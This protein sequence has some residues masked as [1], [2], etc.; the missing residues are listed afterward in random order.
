[1][2]I[3]HPSGA[4]GR[5]ERTFI[6]PNIFRAYD[7]RGRYPDDINEEAVYK[8]GQAFVNYTRAKQILVARDIRFSSEN[9]CNSLIKGICSQGASVLDIGLCSTSCFYFAAATTGVDA[10]LM[11][12]ASHFGKNFNGLKPV[13]AKNV[14]LT[15]DEVKE[16]KDAVIRKEYNTISSEARI[17]RKDF[18][19]VYIDTIRSF[20][21]NKFKPLKIVI[22]ASNGMAGLYVEKIFS[23]TE[24]ETIFI[25][26]EL[27]GNF[28]N[29]EPN[30]K[31]PVNRQKLIEKILREEADLGIMF[32]GDADRVYFLNR[33]G[34]VIDPNLVSALIAEYLIKQTGKKK[35]L[36]EVRTSRAVADYIKKVGGKVEVSVCWTIPIKL[37]MIADPEIIFGSETSGHYVFAD[38]HK[39][40]DGILA[41]ITFLQ[42]ISGKSQSID[43]IIDEFNKKYFIIEETNFKIDNLVKIK[44][45]LKTLEEK[46]EKQGGE[47]MKIDG[48]TVEFNNWWF[49]LRSSETEPF[50]RLN[51]EASNH[52]L[53]EEK[54]KEL[55]TLITSLAKGI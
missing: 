6:N 45:I 34:E 31:I 39:I 47:I 20:I 30:P 4:K 10:S 43:G 41:A 54:K 48:L 46:Y 7:V 52:K 33:K 3:N 40:D 36:V 17:D 2:E 8:I 18:S 37:K 50:I 12:T 28:P 32:D 26:T 25:F 49:N 19:Q 16:L 51:L 21:K 42:A 22:D 55:S 1:M 15:R 29:H 44:E 24:L 11:I 9:L 35:I 38:L 14:P 5:D 23:G 53:M 27:D 13:F